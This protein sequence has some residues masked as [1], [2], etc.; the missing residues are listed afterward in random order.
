[1]AEETKVTEEVTDL[2]KSKNKK[3]EFFRVLKFVGFSASAGIIETVVSTVLDLTVNKSGGYYYICYAIALICS[4][5]WNF[6]FNR[7]FTFK[8]ANN[9]PKAMALALLF[10]V[11]FA[12]WTIYLASVLEDKL[13]N[14]LILVINMAQNITLEYLWQRFVVFRKS[15][16]TNDVAKKDAEKEAEKEIE[17]EAAEAE[18]KIEDDVI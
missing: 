10:Y 18:K 17:K 15:L 14:I 1:M 13:P 6:T 11:P 5:V 3:K 16:D 9:V 4:V 8:A 7:K 12:P 2:E